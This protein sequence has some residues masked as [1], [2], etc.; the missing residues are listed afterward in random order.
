MT[1]H[2]ELLALIL[3]PQGRL[4]V[5]AADSA[6]LPG[7]MLVLALEHKSATG[8][9]TVAGRLDVEQVRLL[10]DGLDLWLRVAA[11]GD[12]QAKPDATT[13]LPGLVDVATDGTVAEWLA[14]GAEQLPLEGL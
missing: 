6:G 5:A 11:R 13:Q 12:V 1:D 14:S 2:T 8:S 3:P 10:R 7:P 4:V 9:Q